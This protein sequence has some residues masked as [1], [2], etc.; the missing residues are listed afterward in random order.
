MTCQGCG[1]PIEPSGPRDHRRKW[2]S[3]RCRKAQ[4]GGT[5]VDCGAPTNGSDG[6]AGRPMR[7]ASCNGKLHG[8][9]NRR[10]T[11]EL[12]VAAIRDWAEEY[13]E[14]PA[15]PDWLPSQALRMNDPGRA[16]RFWDADGRWPHHT[17]VF[18]V[19]GSWNAGIRAAGYEPRAVGGGGGNGARH[20]SVRGR[21]AA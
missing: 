1:T 18:R 9:R 21:V 16:R 19:F 15:V 4:Y 12:V 8:G 2:C 5:C 11:P 20:R 3:E 7:C 14:P 6:Y 17:I 10:W 13:G